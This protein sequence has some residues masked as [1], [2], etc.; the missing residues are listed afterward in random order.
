MNLLNAKRIYLIT[1]LEINYANLYT[2]N[3]KPLSRELRL[4]RVHYANNIKVFN[5][6]AL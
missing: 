6:T 5:K 2:L 3:S 4:I 1:N